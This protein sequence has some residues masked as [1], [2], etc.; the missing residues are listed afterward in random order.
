M[1]VPDLGRYSER[2]QSRSETATQ[3]S[4]ATAQEIINMYLPK[5][6]NNKE[7]EALKLIIKQLIFSYFTPAPF[8]TTIQL[9]IIIQLYYSI[10]IIAKYSLSFQ[11]CVCSSIYCFALKIWH[12]IEFSLTAMVLL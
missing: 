1:A 11:G 4:L 10:S 9:C 5:L 7:T 8:K 3:S 2:I 6:L 12:L